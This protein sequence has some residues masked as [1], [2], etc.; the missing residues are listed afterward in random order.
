MTFKIISQKEMPLLS[1]TKIQAHAAFENVTPSNQDVAKEIAKQ[2]KK[3]EKLVV[4]KKIST[5]YGSKEADIE[6][7]VYDSEKA[8]QS[9]ER[10][11]KKQKE[12]EA[13]AEE[14]AK[15]AAE[16]P[17]ETPKEAKPEEKKEEPAPAE[18]KPAEEKKEEKPEEKSE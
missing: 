9:I 3:D 7:V 2:T 14:E 15:K 13:K 5:H 11:T 4:V 6:A 18:E 10:R 1:R 17:A 12:D 16:A 8:K